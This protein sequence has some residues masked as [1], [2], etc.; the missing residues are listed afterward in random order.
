MKISYNTNICTVTLNET[1]RDKTV[2][3]WFSE[4]SVSYNEIPSFILTKI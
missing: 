3:M 4:S 2:I 1:C